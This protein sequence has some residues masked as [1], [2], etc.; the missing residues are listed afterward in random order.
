MIIILQLSKDTTLHPTFIILKNSSMGFF[1]LLYGRE[2][3]GDTA[4]LYGF[5]LNYECNTYYI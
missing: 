2:G 5:V 4:G 3:G 1:R